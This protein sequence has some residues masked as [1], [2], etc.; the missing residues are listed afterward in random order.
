M[1]AAPTAAAAGGGGGS[2]KSGQAAFRGDDWDPEK[3]PTKK[4]TKECISRLRKELKALFSSEAWCEQQR[5]NPHVKPALLHPPDPLPGILVWTDPKDVTR[6]H[7][8]ITGPEGTPYAGGMF[9]FL[10]VVPA[11]Y[12]H[13]PPRA[14]LLTTGG[15]TV[16]LNP[17]LYMS[18]KVCLSILGTWAGPSWTPAQNISSV[19][20]S[21]QS[22]LGEHPATNEPGFKANPASSA[23][24]EGIVAHETLRVGV[25]DVLERRGELE[26][27]LGEA[28]A[29]LALGFRDTYAATVEA[30]RHLDGSAFAD[31]F[32]RNIGGTN[33]GTF[34]FAALGERIEA[35][36]AEL[37]GGAAAEAEGGA[38][39]SDGDS[40]SGSD[41]D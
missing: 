24:Y 12:P 1:M 8:L 40:S 17:N 21:I 2:S 3:R 20:L 28:V 5:Q 30:W 34:A 36:L 33:S 13:S 14:K 6:L 11:G 39:A 15:G 37:G 29:T 9:T 7:A 41:T 25:L 10:L 22:L 19:L 32:Q 31:P 23:A 27:G 26:E 4:P 38:S 35:A 18:G 16:R